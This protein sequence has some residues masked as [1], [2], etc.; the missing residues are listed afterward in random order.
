MKHLHR[1][2]LTASV[3]GAISDVSAQELFNR[4]W[5]ILPSIN[6][7]DADS[8]YGVGKRGTG[9]GLR[10]GTPLSDNWDFQIGG[11]HTR[12]KQSSTRYQ[13]DVLGMDWL[14]MFSRDVF[15][16]FLL[17]GVGA[18]R[19]KIS[20]PLVSSS[21]TSPYLA[22]GLGFQYDFS[23]HWGTQLDY[24]RVHGRLRDNAF[25]FNRS[26][27]DYVTLGLIFRFD[28][29]PRRTTR[30][31]QAEPAQ[32]PEPIRVQSPPPVERPEPVMAPPPPAPAP[33]PAPR[34]ERFVLSATELFAFD[35]AELK[36]THPKLDEIAAAL[37]SN[38]QIAQVTI[39]GHT[40]RLGPPAYNQ[41]LSNRRAE[42]V[43]NYLINRGVSASRVLASGRGE[44]QPVVDCQQKDRAAL[45]K[46][47]EPNRRVEVE[48][49]AF[50][51]RVP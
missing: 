2:L 25:G 32:R 3:I 39:S 20:R 13:Q 27:N 8:D 1:L 29:A 43:R 47:L 15:R 30:I 48:Q 42:T 10:F 44:T 49:L 23:D 7:L 28:R 22:A 41:A 21:K 45:I 19:D 51:R 4:S 37:N 24:R 17:V 38:P 16:P 50:E 34:F 46:C 14:Y 5:Y 18:E 11:A 36:G 40:D 31:A 35:R 6:R 26:D 12:I 33:P 9:A